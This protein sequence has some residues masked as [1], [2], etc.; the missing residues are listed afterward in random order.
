MDD[1]WLSGGPPYPEGMND[2]A[3]R[4]QIILTPR[5]K[6]AGAEF[7]DPDMLADVLCDLRHFADY[8]GIDYEKAERQGRH[9]WYDERYNITGRDST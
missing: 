8:Y 7:S 2:S 5:V 6:G 3:A 9:N 4:A 1:L